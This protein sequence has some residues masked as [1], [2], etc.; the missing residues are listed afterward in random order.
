MALSRDSLY[1]AASENWK[2]LSQISHFLR[3]IHNVV[4]VLQF[5]VLLKNSDGDTVSK[6]LTLL[7]NP[8]QSIVPELVFRKIDDSA[9]VSKFLL[10][11]HDGIAGRMHDSVIVLEI[12]VLD[13]LLVSFPTE[14]SWSHRW[15]SSQFLGIA[16]H[17]TI[18]EPSAFVLFPL[19]LSTFRSS[20]CCH[21]FIVCNCPKFSHWHQCLRVSSFCWNFVMM[22]LKK[23]MMVPLEELEAASWF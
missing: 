5:L 6:L 2:W 21:C 22:S 18:S 10:K 12:L 20:C 16:S 19:F 9:T 4:S 3:K 7:H 17:Y 8:L 1:L 15:L 14:N 23:F 11:I 13:K